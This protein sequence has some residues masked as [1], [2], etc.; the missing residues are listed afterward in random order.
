VF[1]G[2][3]YGL[4]INSYRGF[5]DSFIRNV[6]ERKSGDL[7]EGMIHSGSHHPG[8]PFGTLLMHKHDIGKARELCLIIP[9]RISRS[10]GDALLGGWAWITS[11]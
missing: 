9:D 5:I 2:D 7:P 10:G 6:N 3:S 4:G 1:N 8:L 11:T